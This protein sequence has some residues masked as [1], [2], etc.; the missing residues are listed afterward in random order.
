MCAEH[1]VIPE[2]ELVVVRI[3]FFFVRFVL[4]VHLVVPVVNRVLEYGVLDIHKGLLGKFRAL[5]VEGLLENSA[6]VD[7]GRVDEGV[8]RNGVVERVGPIGNVEAAEH[9]VAQR[10]VEVNL[11]LGSCVNNAD[12]VPLVINENRVEVFKK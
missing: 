7:V 5:D 9:I 3:F 10:V 2:K 6:M 11:G 4:D 8:G 12:T 1:T